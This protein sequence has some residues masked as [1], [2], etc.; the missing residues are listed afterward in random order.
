MITTYS[1][2]DSLPMH[3]GLWGPMDPFVLLESL[4]L[5]P[6]FIPGS[7]LPLRAACWGRG[8]G[9]HRPS[10]HPRIPTTTCSLIRQLLPSPPYTSFP[11]SLSFLNHR[12]E[13]I[14]VSITGVNAMRSDLKSASGIETAQ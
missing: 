5:L 3:R 6:Y 14:M 11:L 8:E 1:A 12:A 9:T 2:T 13:I 10:P 4:D 7:T